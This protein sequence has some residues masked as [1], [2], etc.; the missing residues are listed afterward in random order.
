[1]CQQIGRSKTALLLAEMTIEREGEGGGGGGG[2]GSTLKRVEQNYKAPPPILQRE[3][4]SLFINSCKTIST[5]ETPLYIILTQCLYLLQLHNVMLGS[6]LRKE[7]EIIFSILSSL[8]K[9]ERKFSLKR[10]IFSPLSPSHVK[11]KQKMYFTFGQNF[12]FDIK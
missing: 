10:I 1:M 7:M 5:H 3:R 2:K 4:E 9:L 12:L 6:F 11:L 8:F